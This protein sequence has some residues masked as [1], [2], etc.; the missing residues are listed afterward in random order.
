M[1]QVIDRSHLEA[2]RQAIKRHA[3]REAYDLLGEA[4]KLE[5]L[6]PDDLNDLSDAAWWTGHLEES[7]SNRQLAY[8]E[9]L[10]QDNPVKAGGMACMLCADHFAKRAHSMA[11]GW[12]GRAERL[13]EGHPDEPEYG[14]LLFMKANAARETGHRDEA[15][16]LAAELLDL[17][18]KLGDRDLQAFG[19][20]LQGKV[21]IS[22]GKVPEG[23]ALLDEATVAAVSGELQPLATGII[24]CIAITSTAD[25][26]DYRRAGEWSEA[27]KR[28]C[29]RQSI[30]GFPGMC[31][32]HRAQIMHLRGDWAEAESDVRLA[33]SEVKDFNLDTAAE[34][35]YE[36]GEIRRRMG[37]F[38]AAREAYRQAEELGREPQPG[39][40]MIQVA[41]GKLRAAAGAVKRAL[42]ESDDPLQRFSLLGC[43]VEIA[44]AMQE[45]DTG[46]AAAG[47]LEEI[48]Q[49][50]GMP[51]LRGGGAYARGILQLHQ[52]NSEAAIDTLRTALRFWKEAD[53]PYEAA[54]TRT[55]LGQAYRAS[56]DE[57]SALVEMKSAASAFQ[58]LGAALDIR[59]VHELMGD[60]AAAARQSGMRVVKSFMFTDIVASTRLVEALG[61]QAWGHLLKWHDKTLRSLFLANG[62]EE[63]KQAGDGFFVAFDR[64]ADALACAASIQRALED[65]RSAHGF[66]PQVRIG[67]YCGEATRREG[68]Y[69]GKEVHKAAR[70][71]ALA[72]PDEIV[73]GASFFR[74]AESGL[75]AQ[76][77]QTVTLRGIDEPVE[78]VKII[79]RQ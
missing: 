47:E 69:E 24:Y 74:A 56:G 53:V 27:A 13:L 1:S 3:W 48:G 57:E 30:S 31:R 76:D 54:R 33:L 50:F 17:G 19:L 25:L 9:Y 58:R 70:I 15:G 7:I 77:P 78:I 4:A 45:W 63:V 61:D 51:A 67:L 32:V 28:W 73:A 8:A 66:A 44:A 16:K 55:A 20:L 62:G 64:P 38:K 6:G 2:G 43:Q 75:P 22:E 18:T 79:W 34:G 60:H 46:E 42:A 71:G 49:K 37:D 12:L 36:L 41:E 11:L 21:L 39:M 23:L 14:M 26:R 72:G 5:P 10:K 59:A 65:H 40:A 52:G 29:E 68:D 35:F